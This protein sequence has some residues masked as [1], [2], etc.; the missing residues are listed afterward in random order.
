M[1]T[2]LQAQ[3]TLKALLDEMKDQPLV[4]QIA[5]LQDLASQCRAEALKKAGELVNLLSYSHKTG[6]E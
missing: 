1:D 5:T 4:T 6:V 3:A 2:F